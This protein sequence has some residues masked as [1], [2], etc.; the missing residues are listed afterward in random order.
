MKAKTYFEKNG[1][2]YGASEKFEFGEWHGYAKK[3]DNLEEAEKWLNTE[4]Y[5][6]RTRSLCSKTYAKRYLQKEKKN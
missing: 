1:F 6:F 3:F 4:E 2:V 5:D